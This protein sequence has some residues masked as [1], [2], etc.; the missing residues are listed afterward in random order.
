M[1]PWIENVDQHPP[2]QC[3][4]YSSTKFVIPTFTTN[5]KITFFETQNQYFIK[6][7]TEQ[8]EPRLGVLYWFTLTTVVEFEKV[9]NTRHWKSVFSQHSKRHKF[10][11]SQNNMC[12]FVWA[13][14][15]VFFLETYFSDASKNHKFV[16]FKLNTFF[17][18]VWW[19]FTSFFFHFHKKKE[20]K[21]KF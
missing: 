9:L 4:I 19:L 6:Y 11:I 13:D 7:T 3:C 16:N 21:I 1:A 17:M 2:V 18:S 12:L 20:M 10:N 15:E 14:D 8:R 5:I